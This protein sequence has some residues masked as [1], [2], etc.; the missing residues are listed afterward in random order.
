VP[1][2]P[3][4]TTVENEAALARGDVRAMYGRNAAACC[5]AEWSLKDS[6]YQLS[7]LDPVAVARVKPFLASQ[8]EYVAI[9]RGQAAQ[10][11]VCDWPQSI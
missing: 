5:T 4:P 6:F 2:L 8:D 10:R 9:R 1:D 7:K 3:G 11:G